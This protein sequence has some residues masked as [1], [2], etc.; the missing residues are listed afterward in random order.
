MQKLLIIIIFLDFAAFLWEDKQ[1]KEMK[2]ITRYNIYI[3]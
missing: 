1:K 3:K 2:N